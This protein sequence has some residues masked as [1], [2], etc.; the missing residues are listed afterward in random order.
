MKYPVIMVNATT[1]ASPNVHPTVETRVLSVGS[2]GSAI[3]AWINRWNMIIISIETILSISKLELRWPLISTGPCPLLADDDFGMIHRQVR[4][5]ITAAYSVKYGA[6]LPIVVISFRDYARH[7]AVYKCKICGEIYDDDEEPVKFED[8]PD[9]WVCPLCRSPK[10]AFVRIDQPEGSMPEPDKVAPKN[11]RPKDSGVDLSIDP[12]FVR[13]DDGPMDEIHRLAETGKSTGEAM[14]TLLPVPSFDSILFLG[15]QLAHPPLDDGA[16]VDISVTIGKNADK[17]MM[18]ESPIYISHMSFGALSG[19]AKKALSIGSAIAKTAMCSGEGGVLSDEIDNAYRY[20]FEY[21]PNKYS[22]TMDT[23]ERCDAVEIKIG[24]GTKPGMGGHLP[25]DKVT[26]IIAAMRGKPKGKDVLSPSRFP[27]I[28]SPEDLKAMVDMLRKETKGKPIGVKIAAGH[29]EEDLEYISKS[30]CDFITIDGRG[31]ATG[32]SPKYLKDASS[33]P[34]LYALSRA[35]RYMYAKGK[36][37]QQD[38]TQA[39][40]WYR[41]SAEQG[42][43]DAQASLGYLYKSG[44]GI[45]QDYKQAMAWYQKAAEKGNPRAQLLIGA[46]YNEGDGVE[47]NYTRALQWYEKAA[48]QN[49]GNAQAAIGL[50]YENGEGVE[51][52]LITAQEYYEKACHNGSNGGCE[53]LELVKQKITN[54]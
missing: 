33:V 4:Y 20:I 40:E 45:Q 52:N 46:L 7:M 54:L 31:G 19:R 22:A 12:A 43:T 6:G 29:I 38:Y 13:H 9:D 42:Y 27:E 10:S 32:S 16:K 35:R 11:E 50:M 5:R 39:V 3:P 51:K 49:Y 36:G 28:N 53:N 47:K 34:T 37:V 8:L 26:D 2:F 14:D 15:G 17:P 23:F 48:N 18:I 21:V 24:Q 25:G 44:K 1:A 41:K 30:G